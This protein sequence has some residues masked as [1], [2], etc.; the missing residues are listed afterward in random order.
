MPRDV[1]VY[2]EAGGMFRKMGEKDLKG[3]EG[4]VYEH[5]MHDV[6]GHL[7]LSGRRGEE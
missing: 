7:S 3:S 5:C 6:G 4:V 1:I 2:I